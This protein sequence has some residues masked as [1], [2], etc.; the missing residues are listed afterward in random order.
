MLAPHVSLLLER[1][2]DELANENRIEDLHRLFELFSRVQ[3]L[4]L[5]KSSWSKFIVSRGS[6]IVNDE[7]P[8]SIEVE[9]GMV[10]TL[11]LFKVDLD[12]T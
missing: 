11:L 8:T 7:S 6:A 3:R 12:R 5:L 1:G 2:F 10:A 9:K 4:P